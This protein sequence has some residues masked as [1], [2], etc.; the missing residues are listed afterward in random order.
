M[1]LSRIKSIRILDAYNVRIV[2][3]IVLSGNVE[4][5]MDIT[6]ITVVMV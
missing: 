3:R 6:N 2:S 5:V 1:K 4:L